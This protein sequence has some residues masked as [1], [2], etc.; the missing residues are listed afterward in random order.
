MIGLPRNRESWFKNRKIKENDWFHFLK[1]LGMDF[2]IFKKGIPITT[3]KGK[4]RNILLV[5]KKFVTCEGRF[6]T[7]FFYHSML[8]MHFVDGNE[9]NFPYFLLQSLKEMEFSIQGESLGLLITLFTI[10][11][12]SVFS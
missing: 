4:W 6:G 10:M 5:I 11:D 3:L 7:M 8:M 12:S 1:E 9:I 2:S